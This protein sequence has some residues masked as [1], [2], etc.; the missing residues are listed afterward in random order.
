MSYT[1]G[2]DYDRLPG[3]AI[4]IN[5]NLISTEPGGVKEKDSADKP[6]GQRRSFSGKSA[7]LEREVWENLA[8]GFLVVGV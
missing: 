6:T 4:F 1:C 3:D 8:S 7:E 2:V 5:S